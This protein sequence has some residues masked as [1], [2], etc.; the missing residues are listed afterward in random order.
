MMPLNRIAL[1]RYFDPG[2]L[3]DAKGVIELLGLAPRTTVSA[4]QARYRAIP[5]P[6]VDL[7]QSRC[8]LWLRSEIEAWETEP[9][10]GSGR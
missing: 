5:R 1:T 9:F 10:A 8:N 2:D 3:I 7:G 6:I 4:Y